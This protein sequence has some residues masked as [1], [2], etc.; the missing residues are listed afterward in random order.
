MSVSNQD[1]D[2]I[3]KIAPLDSGALTSGKRRSM[4]RTKTSLAN[5]EFGFGRKSS[6][7]KSTFILGQRI[8]IEDMEVTDDGDQSEVL[9]NFPS[10]TN[11]KK[12][13]TFKFDTL[14][15]LVFALNDGIIPVQSRQDTPN[16]YI[17]IN[18]AFLQSHYKPSEFK[19]KIN[20][21]SS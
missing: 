17:P 19:N 12:K 21:L 11:A 8:A 5:G 1:L 9:S 16:K 18:T 3:S 6:M 4:I 7:N 14:P 10:A 15:P 20:L 13:A 2:D